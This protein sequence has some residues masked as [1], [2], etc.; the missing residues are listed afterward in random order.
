[1][2]FFPPA[3][4]NLG[5]FVTGKRPD[6]FHDL[7]SVFIAFP[8]TDVLEL[9]SIDGD[10]GTLQLE[11]S[12]IPIP[13]HTEG[14][15][16]VKRAHEALMQAGHDLPAVHVRLH[17]M[18]PIGAGLGGGS[19][20]GTWMLR[21]L[22]A[23]FQL[24]LNSEQLI[25]ISETLG[26][27]CPFFAEEGPA[28]V[29]GRGERLTRLSAEGHSWNGWHLAVVHPNVHVSTRAAFEQLTPRPAPLDLR[30]LGQIPV[31]T[32]HARGVANA[33]EPGISAIV[34]EISEA[35]N[36]V[37]DGAAYVQ[38]TGTGA[39]VFGLY[40][41]AIHAQSIA[42]RAEQMGWKSWAGAL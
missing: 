33:F 31:D 3:K 29:S 37:R 1:M 15:N 23:L 7:E 11:L 26:S 41:D 8:W 38:M 32:W 28:F 42:D 30:D 17:K 19:A 21:G 35:L 27:D 2:L 25:R 18:L 24:G 14:D 5:L 16:L 20:D 13:S 22:N 39:A 6:G 4:L 34:P 9:H 12:G 40:S 10:T 36:L